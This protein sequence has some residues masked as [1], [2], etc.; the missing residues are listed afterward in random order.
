MTAL[1]DL[2]DPGFADGLTDPDV[3]GI[4]TLDTAGRTDGSTLYVARA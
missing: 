1:G 4:D 3:E 2:S